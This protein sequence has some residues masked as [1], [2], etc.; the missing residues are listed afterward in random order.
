MQA[1][2]SLFLT[3]CS[4]LELGTSPIHRLLQGEPNLPI[5]HLTGCRIHLC[6]S[7]LK[8]SGVLSLRKEI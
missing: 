3:F 5:R 2:S 7:H 4:P 6:A 1:A 8:L